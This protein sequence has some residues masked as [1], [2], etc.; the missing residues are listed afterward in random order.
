M[1]LSLKVSIVEKNVVKTLQFE[2]STIVYDACR[3]IREKISEGG[4]TGL[5][6]CKYI[7]LLYITQLMFLI[8][9]GFVYLNIFS[10][11]LE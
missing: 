6:E 10:N 5:G 2:P 8:F 7:F 4:D 3:I 1:S 9:L 11:K